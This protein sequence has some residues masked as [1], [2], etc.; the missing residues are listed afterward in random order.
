MAELR[1]RSER[2]P[3]CK[4]EVVRDEEA[5]L[6]DR[7]G[8]VLGVTAERRDSVLIVWRGPDLRRGRM[9]AVASDV[10]VLSRVRMRSTSD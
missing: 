1:L 2:H 4:V 5:G 7:L 3:R 9:L 8:A 10:P 6:V